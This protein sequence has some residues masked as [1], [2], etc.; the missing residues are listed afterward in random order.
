MSLGKWGLSSG[1]LLTVLQNT[2]A[3]YQDIFCGF[4]WLN[5]RNKLL[6]FFKNISQYGGVFGAD[7]WVCI[8][9]T[10]FLCPITI[11]LCEKIMV[12]S[13]MQSHFLTK[14]KMLKSG[15]R[16]MEGEMER[17]NRMSLQAKQ[18][19]R[20]A[21][22]YVAV[23]GMEMSLSRMTGAHPLPC[24]GPAKQKGHAGGWGQAGYSRQEGPLHCHCSLPQTAA[25]RDLTLQ[26]CS[27]ALLLAAMEGKVP[28][29]E[30]ERHVSLR[31]SSDMFHQGKKGDHQCIKFRS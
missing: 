30:G 31:D 10:I 7:F 13:R 17:I 2:P 24:E 4:P 1:S 15:M 8:V 25:D 19:P 27:T 29:K 12:F 18:R 23:Q 3:G 20:L 9:Q 28:N 16:K 14:N 22:R 26:D 5:L 21:G 6:G 11:Y